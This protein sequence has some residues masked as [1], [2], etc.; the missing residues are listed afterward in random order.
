MPGNRNLRERD[1]QV[2]IGQA[3]PSTTPCHQARSIRRE[4]QRGESHVAPAAAPVQLLSVGAASPLRP[5]GKG[6]QA[7]RQHIPLRGNRCIAAER[8]TAACRWGGR[9]QAA[10]ARQGSPGPQRGAASPPPRTAPPAARHPLHPQPPC[11][12]PRALQGCNGPAG[13]R[14]MLSQYPLLCPHHRRPVFVQQPLQR[15]RAWSRCVAAPGD[16]Q[17]PRPACPP[18]AGTPPCW[19]SAPRC[20]TL[21]ARTRQAQAGSLDARG[22]YGWGAASAAWPPCHKARQAAALLPSPSVLQ[23]RTCHQLWLLID[24]PQAV[25]IHHHGHISP[26]HRTHHLA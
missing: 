20:G 16:H 5:R 4:Q 17:A 10:Q 18:A 19:A 1:C 6:S 13:G 9:L 2:G 24:Q 12:Q 3:A 7:T 8:R 14:Q 21:Q 22:T 23:S 15:R 11:A 25:G 26:P